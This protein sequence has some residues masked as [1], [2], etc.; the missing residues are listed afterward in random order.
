[1]NKLFIAITVLAIGCIGSIVYKSALSDKTSLV[2]TASQAGYGYSSV[3]PIKICEKERIDFEIKNKNEKAAHEAFQ[4]IQAKIGASTYVKDQKVLDAYLSAE[5]KATAAAAESK[6][7][8]RQC[9]IK[10]IKK[11]KDFQG[12][13][14]AADKLLTQDPKSQALWVDIKSEL[15]I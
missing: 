3:T 7:R 15:G 12:A 2:A 8:Y 6:E 5:S 1:M 9:I 4:R 10:T 14:N 13:I 11:S